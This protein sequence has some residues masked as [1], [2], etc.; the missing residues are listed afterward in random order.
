[1]HGE[2]AAA[3]AEVVASVAVRD[4]LLGYRGA[5]K[6][7]LPGEKLQDRQ[8]LTMILNTCHITAEAQE[9]NEKRK[10]KKKKKG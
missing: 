3:V 4:H 1:V 8:W 9:E 6:V 5:A 10:K 7:V 2:V